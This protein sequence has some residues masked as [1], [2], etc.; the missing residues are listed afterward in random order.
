MEYIKAVMT[1]QIIKRSPHDE[2]TLSDFVQ[3]EEFVA[4]MLRGLDESTQ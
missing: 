3:P 1:Y 4:E 2:T